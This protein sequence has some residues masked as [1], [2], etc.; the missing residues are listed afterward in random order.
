MTRI[1]IALASYNG[2]QFIAEQLASFSAQTR[3]PDEL[4]VSDDGSTDTTLQIVEAFAADAPFSVRIIGHRENVGHERNFER[5][6]AA[7]TGDLVFLSDQDDVWAPIKLETVARLFEERPELQVVINDLTITDGALR[8]TGWTVLGQLKA[9]GNWGEG[10]K[11]FV[12]GCA[13]AYRRTLERLV[14]PIPPL[15]YG[16][17]RWLHAVAHAVGGRLVLPIALQYFRRHGGNASTML[18]E[19]EKAPNWSQ[20]VVWS[21][22]HDLRSSYANQRRVMQEI[23]L[24]IRELPEEAYPGIRNR[25]DVLARLAASQRAFDAR[26]SLLNAG[27]VARRCQALRM[28]LRGEY[29]HFLGWRSF[30]KDLIR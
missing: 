13:T 10:R 18:C 14:L 15:C 20:M 2:A 25:E 6:M 26:L 9:S 16:H 22:D 21:K 3:L 24:R 12:V 8:P 17:D 28:L 30:A 4:V 29:H 19:H 23:E 27:P 11:T 5:A 1:S 7:C